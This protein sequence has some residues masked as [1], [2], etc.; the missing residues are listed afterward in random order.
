[1]PVAQ[2]DTAA[3]TSGVAVLLDVLANDSDADGD[4]L[5]ITDTTLT[6]GEGT[7]LAING[8]VQYTPPAGF[9]GT[10]TIS[11]TI[12]DDRLGVASA[13]ATVTVTNSGPVAVNDN[14][15][16]NE[17]EVLVMNA[18]GVLANDTD[19]DGDTP[20]AALVDGPTH[21]TLTLNANG[22]FTYTPATNFSGSDSFTYNAADGIG[23]SN[24]ATVSITVNSVNDAP[25]AANDSA[26]TLEDAAVTIPVL[27]M[28]AMVD[29]DTLSAALASGPAHARS[30]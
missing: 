22:S 14:Y 15:N 25:V 24:P 8:Q 7:V 10:A 5:T 16:V 13:I 11:Y 18:P 19:V 17:D 4:S 21:G 29:G 20:S 1:V 9:S 28:T 27:A 12:D 23:T 30:R 6:S 2:N 26:T 3:T